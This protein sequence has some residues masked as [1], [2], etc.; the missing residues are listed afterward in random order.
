MALN[1]YVLG[2]LR[3]HG[4]KPKVMYT[5]DEYFIF[6]GFPNSIMHFTMSRTPGWLWGCW[7]NGESMESPD[8]PA[9]QLFCQHK[10][11]IDKFKP[12]ASD[13][14]IEITFR[15]LHD[16]MFNDYV[17]KYVN[18]P[19]SMRKIAALADFVRM[20]PF[21]AYAGECDEYLPMGFHPTACMAYGVARWAKEKTCDG[22]VR[23]AARAVK[24]AV[25]LHPLVERAHVSYWGY[26]KAELRIVIKDGVDEVPD[27]MACRTVSLFGSTLRVCTVSHDGEWEYE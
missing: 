15:E 27:W 12:S 25:T 8:K 3:V 20:H 1:Q 13:C 9:I 4:Y 19:W 18:E 10:T 14:K 21:L 22:V 23:T 26:P 24:K 11:S 17:T 6:S 16:V 7:V 2:C 5:G